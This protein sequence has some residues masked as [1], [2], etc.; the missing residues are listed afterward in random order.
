MA[1]LLLAGFVTT[2]GGAVGI[3]WGGG[4]AAGRPGSS[5][6]LLFHTWV[7]LLCQLKY[8]IIG[9]L[10]VKGRVIFGNFYMWVL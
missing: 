10:H 9:C 5:S 7:L 4:G 2:V 1:A 3:C 6:G 8:E